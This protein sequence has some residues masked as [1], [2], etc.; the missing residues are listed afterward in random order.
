MEIWLSWL[1]DALRKLTKQNYLIIK[2]KFWQNYKQI[3]IAREF[4]M[5]SSMVSYRYKK[6]IEKLRNYL[7]E[8]KELKKG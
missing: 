6:S 2:K 3:E 5:S 7:T 8:K 4:K 1:R